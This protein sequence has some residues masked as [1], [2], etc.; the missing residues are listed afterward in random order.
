M[1]NSVF[2]ILF[3]VLICIFLVRT[4]GFAQIESRRADSIHKGRL[5]GVAIGGSVAYGI[6]MVGLY[7]LW[8]KDFERSP[9]HF[10]D[11]SKDWLQMDKAGHS[12]SVYLL[13]D[14]TYSS[15]RW[16]GLSK[17]KSVLYGALSGWIAVTSIEFFDGHYNGWGFSW[18][19]VGANSFG[20]A[21][22]A[23][24]Q[25]A[26]DEQRIQFK[27]SFRTTKYPQYRPGTLGSN[28][29]EQMTKDYNG[30][31]YWLSANLKSFTKWEFLPD[32][33]NLAAGY[34]AA[35]LLGGSEN[36]ELN[37]GTRLPQFERQRQFYL[38]P[39][40]DFTKIPTKHKGVKTLFK[41]LNTVK[42]PA[43]AVRLQD[44]NIRFFGIY[45]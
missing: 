25:L 20:T 41:I 43:P 40:I 18:A 24:Q 36:P 1:T 15:L 19:D 11:D 42:L 27:Y 38:S 44:G 6:T 13:S 7:Q 23:G 39:D 32:W 2:R 14:L 22:F 45:H 21:L 30:Q 29:I 26:W 12:Y 9:F 3:F 10:F 16:T 4:T 31:S 34:S 33:L 5:R 28:F 17:R 35:G 37:N 8:Y